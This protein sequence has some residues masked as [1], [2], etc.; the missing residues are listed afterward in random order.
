MRLAAA[1]LCV[2][3]LVG[4]SRAP[5]KHAAAPRAAVVDAGPPPEPA[6]STAGADISW[7]VGTWERQSGQKEWL[8]FNAPKE[9]AVIAGKPPAMIARGEFVPSGRSISLFFRGTGGTQERVLEAAP[10]RSELHEVGP[11]PATYRRGAPP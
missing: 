1:A 8:L 2:G 4:C 5:E 7:L 6:F 11:T 10:D 3:A 9:V